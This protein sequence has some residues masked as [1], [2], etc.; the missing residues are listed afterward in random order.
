M[1]CVFHHISGHLPRQI[2]FWKISTK[3]WASVRPPNAKCP[4]SSEN[5]FW[6]PPLL[7]LHNNNIIANFSSSIL[8]KKTSTMMLW[9]KISIPRLLGPMTWMMI[10]NLNVVV[11]ACCW[12]KWAATSSSTPEVEASMRN[13]SQLE[14]VELAPKAGPRCA[15]WSTQLQ[16]WTL[17][18]LF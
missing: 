16:S 6:G 8:L 18:A 2:C 9:K 12:L 10:L 4:T 3:T 14:L 5:G 11:N 13:L 1:Y 15:G 7:S 17:S